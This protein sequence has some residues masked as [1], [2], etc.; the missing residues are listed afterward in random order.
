MSGV[1]RADNAEG[2]VRLLE[3]NYGVRVERRGGGD[4]VLRGTP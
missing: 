2:F 4:V 3:T 1:F